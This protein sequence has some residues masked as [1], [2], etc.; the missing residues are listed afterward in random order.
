MRVMYMVQ[1]FFLGLLSIVPVKILYFVSMIV[2]FFVWTD[3]YYLDSAIHNFLIVG[4][5]EEFSKFIIFFFFCLKLRSIKEPGDG[6]LQA[7][8]VALAFAAVEN[9]Y[10]GMDYGV[11]TMLERSV[12]TIV[13]HMVYSSIWSC[14]FAIVVYSRHGGSGRLRFGIAFRAIVPAAFVHGLYNFLLDLGHVDLALALD[15]LVLI[16]AVVIYRIMLEESPY[17]K[18]PVAEY[19]RAIRRLRLGLI[20]H[21]KSYLLNRRMAFYQLYAGNYATALEHFKRCVLYKPLNRF[22]K[23]FKG[24]TL[25]LLGNL[26]KGR[27]HLREAFAYLGPNGRVTL[28][29]M[30]R[31]FVADEDSRSMLLQELRACEIQGRHYGRNK[32]V[33]VGGRPRR[34]SPVPTRV[35]HR[36]RVVDRSGRSYSNILQ[37]KNRELREALKQAG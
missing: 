11:E 15:V 12:L 22:M 16:V 37:E 13:G 25:L 1:F 18:L 27:T 21:P 30:V 17:K 32:I 4:P 34:R 19:R 8:A 14:A 35:V 24:L 29:R 3:N 31:R 26:F 28:R 6:I 36:P 33:R 10:Y 5:I 20:A 9:L 2:E 23:C 7:A